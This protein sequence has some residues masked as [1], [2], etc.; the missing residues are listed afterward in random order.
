MAM[1]EEARK[2]WKS[3]GG[4]SLLRTMLRQQPMTEEGQ[5]ALAEL[6][7]MNELER[8]RE[9]AASENKAPPPNAD[10]VA[11]RDAAAGDQPGAKC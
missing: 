6:K 11:G 1:S 3:K 9:R 10:A 5:A 8:A 2:V 4:A 7:V